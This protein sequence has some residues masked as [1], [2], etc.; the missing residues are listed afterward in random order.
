M[1]TG[2][3]NCGKERSKYSTWTQKVAL[4]FLFPFLILAVGEASAQGLI[5]PRPIPEVPRPAPL[6]VKRQKVTVRVESGVA[7]AEVEQVFLNPYSREMEG[8]YLFP[9][10]EGAAVSNFRMTVDRE[11]LEGKILDREEARAIYE[12]YVRRMVDP[13][14]LEYVGRGAFRARVFPIPAQGEKVIQIGY[15]QPLPFEAGVYELRVPLVSASGV[16]AGDALSTIDA[17]RAPPG[18]DAPVV[19]GEVTI[20]SPQ[21]LRAIYSPTHEVALRRVDDRTARVSFESRGGEAREFRLYYS[22]SEKEFGLNVL[23]HRRGDEPGYFMLMLAPKR[24]V[25]R[26]AVAPKDLMLVCD[27][28]GSMSGAKIEQAKGALRFIVQNLNPGD[29]FN[30]VRF[31]S[32]VESF[33]KELIE[34]TPA[35][36]DAA[37]AWVDE[38]R[39]VGGTA[40]DDALAT[41]FDSLPTVRLADDSARRTM[42][43]FLTDGQP[44]VGET[45]PERILENARRRLKGTSRVFVFG[46]G[47]DVNTL[48]LDRLARDGAGTVEYV[49]PD[50]DLEL[51]LSGFYTK[52]ADPVLTDLEISLPGAEITDLYPRR[53]PDLFAGSQLIVF[54]RY[55]QAAPVRARLTGRLAG[56]PRGYTYDLRLP[57]RE[58]EHGFIPRLWASRKIGALLEEI[59]LHGESAE[60]K[61]EVIRLS[62]EHGIVTPYTSFLVEEPGARRGNLAE[63]DLAL[64]RGG[65]GGGGPPGP[66]GPPGAVGPGGIPGPPGPPGPS[67]EVLRRRADGFQQATGRAAVDASVRIGEL[68]VQAVE[69]EESV[70]LRRVGERLFHRD[71]EA[72]MQTT[73]SKGLPLLEVKWGSTAYFELVRLRPDLGPT[74]ALGRKLTLLLTSKRALRVG[75]T[76]K[77]ALTAADRQA[78]GKP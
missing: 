59:R 41:A 65:Y 32:E 67:S 3:R 54:G 29:R 26:A 56:Q 31:N 77:T 61:G 52:I 44:T 25:A 28:S 63:R 37:R 75:D 19:T 18:G 74:L 73:Y 34:A 23:A 68:K 15:S 14:L 24:E 2:D 53:L 64:G 33:R 1:Q 72:W 40:I 7:R 71:G 9:L 5:L 10:P 70:G 21:A 30:M 45:N 49:R 60:L 55:R 17:R 22:V 46:V 66:Q 58:R 39:A 43:V 16:S 51:K 42:I 62:K 4:G 8:T 57:D 50:E 36:R 78:L 69:Q 12:G 38:I 35:A 20:R 47:D 6:P 13:A 48:L 11:P 27:T 76:G